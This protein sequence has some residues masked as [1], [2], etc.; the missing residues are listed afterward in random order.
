MDIEDLIEASSLGTPGA[1]ALRART[2]PEVVAEVRRRM[3]AYELAELSAAAAAGAGQGPAS[4]GRVADLAHATAN[5]NDLTGDTDIRN[6]AE[7]FVL[8]AAEHPGIPA[9]TGAMMAWF[10]G[11]MAAARDASR[12]L[13]DITL[14]GHSLIRCDGTVYNTTWLCR[15]CGLAAD[16]VADYTDGPACQA[17][18]HLALPSC[19]RPIL[20]R[21][22]P[23]S[24]ITSPRP[25]PRTAP[26]TRRSALKSQRTWR[27]GWPARTSAGSS[28]PTAPR[29][30]RS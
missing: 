23:R 28:P 15:L 17:P 1:K 27:T 26:A 20:A 19:T 10:A 5:D 12:S 18:R 6:W 24:L 7:R 9:D 21:W 13:T 14:N 11:A 29:S 8:R 25:S 22:G 30:A 3:A 2:P 16:R 4:L